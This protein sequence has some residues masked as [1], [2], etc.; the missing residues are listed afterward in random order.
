MALT[1]PESV[2]PRIAAGT[3]LVAETPLPP[4]FWIAAALPP[5]FMT[6]KGALPLGG[7]RPVIVASETVASC[8]INFCPWRKVTPSV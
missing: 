7:V 4:A 3:T 8:P 5:V 1:E 6:G 2:R